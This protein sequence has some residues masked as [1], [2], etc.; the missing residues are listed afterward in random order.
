MKQDN[1]QPET[2]RVK[3]LKYLVVF[4][5]FIIIISAV[6]L[7]VFGVAKF[8]SSAQG[9]KVVAVQETQASDLTINL[10][11][12]AQVKSTTVLNNGDVAVTLRLSQSREQIMI[13]DPKSG[14]IKNSLTLQETN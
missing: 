11:P 8:K 10:P 12:R 14:Q 5:G 1:T 6:L 4:L 2:L 9:D 7:I 3:L 13:L